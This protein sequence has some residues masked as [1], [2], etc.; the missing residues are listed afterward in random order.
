MLSACW[1]RVVRVASVS[2]QVNPLAG[3]IGGAARIAQPETCQRL[4]PRTREHRWK[5]RESCQL[6]SPYWQ[7]PI[8][9]PKELEHAI[10][11]RRK[12]ESRKEK[13]TTAS[14]IGQYRRTI[15]IASW[16]LT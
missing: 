6:A 14:A 13:E 9:K 7:D 11:F 10:P 15:S 12:F 4:L 5:E 2:S 1:G 16:Y 3:I 8:I